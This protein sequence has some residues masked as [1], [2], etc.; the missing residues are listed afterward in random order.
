MSTFKINEKTFWVLCLNQYLFSIKKI[1]KKYFLIIQ[2]KKCLNLIMILDTLL[3]LL[4]FLK[5][6]KL[7]IP[8]KI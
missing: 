2:Q 8:K 3:I 1:L 6:L 5:M 4:I 7:S